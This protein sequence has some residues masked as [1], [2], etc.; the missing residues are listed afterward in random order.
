MRCWWGYVWSK[1]HIVCIWSSW[2]HCHLKTP[3]T[4][5][6]FK[7]RLALPFWYGLT[8]VVLEKRPLNGCSSSSVLDHTREIHDRDVSEVIT[9]PIITARCQHKLVTWQFFSF[10]LYCQIASQ[11]QHNNKYNCF[12]KTVHNYKQQMCL[13]V[14]CQQYQHVTIDHNKLTISTTKTATTTLGYFWGKAIC[15]YLSIIVSMIWVN[16]CI[17]TCT[18]WCNSC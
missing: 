17:T 10:Q 13:K 1:V 9:A 6:S 8:Q 2:C 5:A 3:S 18:S 11:P 16:V 15:L 12:H 14:N 4:L 7:S